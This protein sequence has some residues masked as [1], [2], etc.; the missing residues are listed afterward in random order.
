MSQTHAVLILR[1]KRRR[2]GVGTCRM[3]AAK[4]QHSESCVVGDKK[5]FDEATVQGSNTG[6]QCRTTAV[7]CYCIIKLFEIC[8]YWNMVHC[9]Q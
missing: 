7:F 6:K 8:H 9:L 3:T 4:S 2:G 5:T 1:L